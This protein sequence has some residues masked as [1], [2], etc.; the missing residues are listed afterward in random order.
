MR[1]GSYHVFACVQD[2]ESSNRSTVAQWYWKQP[3]LRR[4]SEPAWPILAAPLH[5]MR[6]D[7]ILSAR[8]RYVHMWPW[9]RCTGTGT[10]TGACCCSLPIHLSWKPRAAET[11]DDTHRLSNTNKLSVNVRAD[12]WVLAQ[13]WKQRNTCKRVPILIDWLAK[14]K[15]FPETTCRH[16]SHWS[17]WIGSLR[18]PHIGYQLSWFVAMI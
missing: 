1:Q 15:N 12:A 8:H 17:G 14:N 18:Q 7:K 13:R 6:R 4:R 3:R 11:P 10:G 2:L 9:T 5:H 16:W